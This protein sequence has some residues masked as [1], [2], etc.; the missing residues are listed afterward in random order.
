[1]EKL[2]FTELLKRAIANENCSQITNEIFVRKFSH[3]TI[4]VG[5]MLPVMFDGENSV[6]IIGLQYGLDALKCF[7]ELIFKL[8][9]QINYH[10]RSCTPDEAA[11]NS[12][13]LRYVNDYC[14]RS[15]VEFE[16]HY[17]GCDVDIFSEIKGPFEQIEKLVINVP[18]LMVPPENLRLNK[19]FPLVGHLDL[20]FQQITTPDFIDCSFPHLEEFSI[21]A[22][23]FNETFEPTFIN[24]ITKNPQ[25]KIMSAVRPS[26]NALRLINEHLTKL[27]E[28]L[29]LLE[30]EE[31]SDLD[32]I[33]FTSLK[34]LSL[35]FPFGKCHLPEKITFGELEEI[36]L[37]CFFGNIGDDYI[38]FLLKYQS[39]KKLTLGEGLNNVQILKL[40]G[41][42]PYLSEVVFI[43]NRDVSAR[44]IVKFV[45]KSDKLKKLGFD[46]VSMAKPQGYRRVLENE[47]GQKFYINYRNPYINEFSIERRLATE[48]SINCATEYTD[49]VMFLIIA[50]ILRVLL[51]NRNQ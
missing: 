34:K 10:I 17:A 3:T 4:K 20:N 41:K 28:L 21:A 12:Q 18:K 31:D 14:R 1:M 36:A 42:L 5:N 39:I 2:D 6:E 45:E 33:H 19:I 7:G 22:G 49:R 43:D 40:A 44:T 23:M 50:C 26:Q 46:Q 11:Q 51:L 8:A 35:W 25:I 37:F 27:E 15:L 32:E 24:I 13:F 47:L 16:M 48:N 29:C 30:I 38:D 9:I